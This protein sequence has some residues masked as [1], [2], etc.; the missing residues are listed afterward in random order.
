MPFSASDNIIGGTNAADA[1]TIAF[2]S[3]DGVFAEGGSRNS[4][5][6]NSI[7]DNQPPAAG[8][9][10]GIDL[11]PDGVTP[12]DS[13]DPDTG[14]NGLQNF[15]ELFFAHSSETKSVVS[16]SLNSQAN[17]TYRLE[18]FANDIC[19][20]SNNGEGQRFLGIEN[21]TTDGSGN[22]FF[23]ATV[24]LAPAFSGEWIT[25]TATLDPAGADTNDD[26][27]EFAACVPCDPCPD[28]P[29]PTAMA[30]DCDGLLL[31]SS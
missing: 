1:N 26:T 22:A 12:N 18:F 16:G 2:N 4:I 27:S 14:A 23:G 29:P 17:N 10:L 30:L 20:P 21:V 3:G 31:G 9:G 8:S 5:L 13:G 19:D 6:R 28:E 25:A 7:H 24:S 15:P 11:A